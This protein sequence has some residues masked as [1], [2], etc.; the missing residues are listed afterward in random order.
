MSA[1][2]ICALILFLAAAVPA[3]AQPPA[4]P[5]G[6]PNPPMTSPRFLQQASLPGTAP[7]FC[8]RQSA[9]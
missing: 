5:P 2:R 9:S 8:D 6:P 7:G 3:A 4:P 1:K